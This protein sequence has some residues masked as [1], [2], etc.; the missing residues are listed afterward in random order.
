MWEGGG[1]G[2]YPPSH[3]ME[4]FQN[5]NS[6]IAG[7]DFTKAYD[8]SLTLRKRLNPSHLAKP[9][10]DLRWVSVSISQSSYDGFTSQNPSFTHRRLTYTQRVDVDLRRILQCIILA[11][12]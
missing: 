2:W 12:R 4:L 3:G 8:A 10:A 9:V 1:G 6:K 7:V 11:F 5:N